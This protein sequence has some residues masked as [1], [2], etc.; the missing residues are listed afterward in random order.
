MS[1]G[2]RF[3]QSPWL[4]SERDMWGK[5]NVA[6]RQKYSIWIVVLDLNLQISNMVPCFSVLLLAILWEIFA[7]SIFVMITAYSAC[8][9]PGFP[10]MLRNILNWHY[11][12]IFS[13]FK[14]FDITPNNN[15][16]SVPTLCQ[17]RNIGHWVLFYSTKIYQDYT[18][19]GKSSGNLVCPVR[20]V[21]VYSVG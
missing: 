13:Y 15:S 19:K 21:R 8:F 6:K 20:A 17:H 12:Y 7:S 18:L 1:Q 14:S 5:K 11:I 16:V 2:I 3:F 10:S 9:S 4:F